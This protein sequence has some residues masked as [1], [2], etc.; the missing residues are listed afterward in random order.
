MADLWKLDTVVPEAFR[1]AGLAAKGRLDMH[2]DRAVRIAC[3]DVF[4]RSGLLAKIIPRIEEVL[5]AGALPR[6][7]PQPEA[8]G[9]AFEDGPASGDEGHRG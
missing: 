4:R 6:P 9:P 7:E 1:V 5:E 8:H 3:R 2:P